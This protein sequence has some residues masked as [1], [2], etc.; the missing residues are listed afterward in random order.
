MRD[1]LSILDNKEVGQKCDDDRFVERFEVGCFPEEF[2]CKFFTMCQKG[3]TVL[4]GRNVGKIWEEAVS[5]LMRMNSPFFVG[6][7]V[8]DGCW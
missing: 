3:T 4:F 1:L 8:N 6:R 5:T 2:F 7:D